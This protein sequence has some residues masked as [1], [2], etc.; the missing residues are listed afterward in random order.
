MFKKRSS[1]SSVVRLEGDRFNTLLEEWIDHMNSVPYRSGVDFFLECR[2][3]RELSRGGR[4]LIPLVRTTIESDKGREIPVFA[5]T[6][7]AG[8]LLKGQLSLPYE[9]TGDIDGTRTYILDAM[10]RA[11]SS[12]A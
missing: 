6:A 8:V 11:E 2:A 4:E 9:L 3:Y 12:Y 5:W 1:V 7:L 10:R